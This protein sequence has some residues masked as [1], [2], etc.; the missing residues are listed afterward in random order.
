[1][2]IFLTSSYMSLNEYLPVPPRLGKHY[3]AECREMK[4]TFLDLI[5]VPV[6]GSRFKGS[7]LIAA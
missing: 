2:A 3:W 5:Y 1:V 6:Q 4:L 7:R